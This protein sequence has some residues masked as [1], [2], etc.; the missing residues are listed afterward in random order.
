MLQRG[1][2]TMEALIDAAVDYQAGVEG[3][4]DDAFRRGRHDIW[5][6]GGADTYYNRLPGLLSERYKLCNHNRQLWITTKQFYSELR[7]PL[8]HGSQLYHPTPE[9]LLQV[10]DFLAELQRWINAWCSWQT[11]CPN[12][13]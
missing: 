7:N 1:I 3:R 6:G 4:L 12:L 11:G 10:F 9:S 5:K 2:L 8:F 13:T